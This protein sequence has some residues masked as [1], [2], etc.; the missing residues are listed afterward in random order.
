VCSSDL[1]G[2]LSVAQQSI[3]RGAIIIIATAIG[4]RSNK[5]S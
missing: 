4:S 1:L 3:V 5:K 2:G